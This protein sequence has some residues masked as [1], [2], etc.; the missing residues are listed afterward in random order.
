MYVVVSVCSLGVLYSLTP[1][2]LMS[3]GKDETRTCGYLYIYTYTFVKRK[4]SQEKTNFV[5][6]SF[7]FL[8]FK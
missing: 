4:Y 5:T 6:T 7:V 1:A 3:A 8:L 2:K